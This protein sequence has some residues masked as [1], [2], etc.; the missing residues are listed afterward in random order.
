MTERDDRDELDEA[1]PP[2]RV[3][4]PTGRD[5]YGHPVDFIEC[6]ADA[7]GHWDETRWSAHP[8]L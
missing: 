5:L 1:E 4:V 6:D 2:R 8:P 7:T 3:V